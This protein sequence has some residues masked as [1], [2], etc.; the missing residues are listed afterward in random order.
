MSSTSTNY[1]LVEPTVSG[2]SDVWGG[3]LNTTITSIDK[4]LTA[5][6]T[7]GSANAYLLTTGQSLTA[8][9]TGMRFNII[10]NFSNSGACTVNVDGIGAKNLYRYSDGA[11]AACVSG[12]VVSGV[13]ISIAYDGTQFVISSA[14]IVSATLRAIDAVSWSSGSPVIQ[15]TAA[16]TVSLTNTPTFTS[17]VAATPAA[18]VKNTADSASNI[19]LLVASARATPTAFDYV[20]ID[21]KLNNASSSQ[22]SVAQFRAYASAV[23]AGAETGSFYWATINAG[24]AM[25]LRMVMTSNSLFPNTN[26]AMALGGPSN[27]WADFFLA[28]GGVI[29]WNNGTY[30]LTQSGSNL[31]AS[32][33]IQARVPLSSETSGTLTTASANKKV[34]CSGGI[35]IPNSVF[36]ADDFI[37]FDAGTSSRTFTRSSTNMY[38][39]GTD[40]ASA[41]LASNQMGTVHFRAATVAVLSGAFS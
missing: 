8:Y 19:G 29:N 1:K 27:S 34:A 12:D 15:F 20:G 9:T 21:F 28:S 14:G 41:T 4:L 7:T 13:P 16:D 3:Y 40:S 38:V 2:D 26:D 33:T 39:N 31:A 18:T 11:L 23:T 32:G 25:T 10:P 17:T 36:T 30:T 35:T 24:G 37:L 5:I 22:V 6:A